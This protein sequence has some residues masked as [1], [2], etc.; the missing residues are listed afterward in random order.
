MAAESP[1]LL[2][3]PLFAPLCVGAGVVASVAVGALFGL[4]L[5]LLVAAASALSLVISLVWQSL[6][7]LSGEA[8]LTLEEAFSLAAPTAE[9][10]QKRAV[11]RALKD[12]E[13]ELRVGKISQADYL[14][15]SAR[16][17]D[18]AKRLI[19]AVDERLAEQRAHAERLLDERLNPKTQP[20]PTSDAE[21]QPKKKRKKSAGAEVKKA[22]P[23]ASEESAAL[24]D[25]PVSEAPPTRPADTSSTEPSDEHED[26]QDGDA[27]GHDDKSRE[28]DEK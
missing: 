2:E 20:S 10:E 7:H 27:Q 13:Y 19:V 17:R 5:G 28:E 11:L 14:E 18:E 4:P 6:S 8:E 22:P 16:Y 24:S 1:S 25:G 21:Q 3:S 23:S 9:E 26:E 15:L 12:L